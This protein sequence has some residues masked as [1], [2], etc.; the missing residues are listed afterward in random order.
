V[1]A[2]MRAK[3]QYQ[4]T[5]VPRGDGRSMK[6]EIT[7][8]GIGPIQR[9]SVE[10]EFDLLAMLELDHSARLHKSIIAALPSGTVI[11]PGDDPRYLGRLLA[12]QVKTWMDSGEPVPDPVN[13]SAEKIETLRES[14]V[15]EGYEA[16]RIDRVFAKRRLELGA[17]TDEYVDRALAESQERRHQADP[18]PQPLG[19]QVTQVIEQAKPDAPETPKA[20]E[21]E[22]GEGEPAKQQS[23]EA[24]DAATASASA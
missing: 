3:T 14:L 22:G 7:K 19:E 13:A 8:L 4:V 18:P 12:Q 24:P 16:D 23:E 11:D 5:E 20:P 10:Y 21:P 2:T 1:I 17:L 15:A 6:Q 9:E